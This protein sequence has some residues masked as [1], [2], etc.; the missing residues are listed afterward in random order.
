MGE[1]EDTSSPGPDEYEDIDEED[2]TPSEVDALGA[3]PPPKPPSPLPSPPPPPRRCYIVL[4]EKATPLFGSRFSSVFSPDSDD[5]SPEKDEI[6]KQIARLFKAPQSSDEFP[7]YRD[8]VL[9]A[10]YAAD[11]RGSASPHPVPHIP[12]QQVETEGYVAD[13]VTTP[14]LR[15]R[16]GI[17]RSQEQS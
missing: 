9:D 10:E 3:T 11:K 1:H 12:D 2:L 14:G 8:P 7:E 13:V 4:D 5:H 16:T 17:H 15:S 6:R